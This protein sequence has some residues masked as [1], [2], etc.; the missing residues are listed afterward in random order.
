[1]SCKIPFRLASVAR[2]ICKALTV[3]VNI[4]GWSDGVNHFLA[5]AI[6]SSGEMR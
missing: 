3:V 4:E 6:V 5:D 2:S 1:M